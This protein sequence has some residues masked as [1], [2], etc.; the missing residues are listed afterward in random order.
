MALLVHQQRAALSEALP[1]G[2]ADEGPLAAV[3]GAVHLQVSGLREAAAA[4][5][6]AERA[7]AR[8]DEPMAPQVGRHA[9]ALPAGVAA[10]GLLSG[11]DTAVHRQAAPAGESVPTVLAG[12]RPLTRVRP[13]VSPEAALL[14]ECLPA[15]AAGE[16]PQSSVDGQLVDVDAAACGES[17]L[18][19]WTFKRFLLQVD[20]LVCRQVAVFGELLPALC[21]P[22]LLACFLTGQSVLSEEAPRRQRLAAGRTCECVAGAPPA[23]RLV[24]PE[25]AAGAEHLPAVRTPVGPL[26]VV[27][28]ELVDSDAAPGGES[29][30]AGGAGEGPLSA[31]DPQVSAQVGPSGEAAAADAA[32]EGP[33]A[34]RRRS[35]LRLVGF[36]CTSV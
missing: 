25:V 24:R 12:V 28:S 15:D 2:V 23:G 27:H 17:F 30:P 22:E 35:L 6:T 20:S 5:V 32:A 29:F 19:C 31:V 33:S 34:A 7:V 1:T 14:A 13:Q 11:V 9:E 18:T 3:H 10:E 36:T 26:L 16:R 8:V 21:A 4:H